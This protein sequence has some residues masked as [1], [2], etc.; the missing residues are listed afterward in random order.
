MSK[1]VLRVG[2]TTSFVSASSENERTTAGATV[3][4]VRNGCVAC[5]RDHTDTFNFPME[6]RERGEKLASCAARAA[7]EE[8]HF[9][10]AKDALDDRGLFAFVSVPFRQGTRHNAVFIARK[11]LPGLDALTPESFDTKYHE[12]MRKGYS[13]CYT[14]CSEMRWLPLHPLLAASGPSASA[15]GPDDDDDDER[16]STAV[17]DMGERVPL[18]RTTVSVLRNA[19]VREALQKHLTPTA[20]AQGRAASASSAASAASASAA[21]TS[22]DSVGVDDITLLSSPNAAPKTTAA[23]RAEWLKRAVA[24]LDSDSSED[25]R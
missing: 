9:A 22:A 18:R 8:L 14:E 17:T 6:T 13:D 10:V 16:C 3:I 23:E 21:P 2:Q 15:P 11:E 24:A 12:Y 1:F 7:D 4:L 20:A 25:D 5:V 19:A